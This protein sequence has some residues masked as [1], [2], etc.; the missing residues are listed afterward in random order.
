M[1]RSADADCADAAKSGALAEHV[2]RLRGVSGWDDDE[3][4][5][6]QTESACA[7]VDVDRQ[8]NG[9]PIGDSVQAVALSHPGD[10]R[11][12]TSERPDGA[13]APLAHRIDLPVT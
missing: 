9:K 2:V 13:V 12:E 3:V 4:R 5:A 1:V 11:L 10:D 8:S 6:T 7:D